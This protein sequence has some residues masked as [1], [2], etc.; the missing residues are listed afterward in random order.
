MSG[1]WWCRQAWQFG[2][3][4]GGRIAARLLLE[5]DARARAARLRVAAQD[6]AVQRLRPSR[7]RMRTLILGPGGRLRWR[8]V[9]APAP[10]G[11]FGAIVHPLA[12]AT[13]DM[14]R[15]LALGG[16]P[17]PV[18]LAF[19]HEC[20]AEVLS[21]GSEV[22]TVGPGQRVV[23]PFQISC[24]SCQACRTG[25]SANCVAVPPLSMYG[26]G[27][28]GGH[29]GG[30]FADEL[31]VPFADG[32]LVALPE[33]VAPAVAASVAD[34][35]SDAY[36]HVGPHLQRVLARGE[37]PRVIVLGGQSKRTL[38][39]A[40][41]P[42]YAG[43]I[44]KALGAGEVL[45]ID[46][47]DHVRQ[48]AARLGLNAL[49]PS[50]AKSL[51]PASLV[52]DVSATAGGLRRAIDLTAPDGICSSSGTLHPKAA[53]PTALMFG[54]NA[55]LTIGR[56]HARA[57]IPQVL[58]LMTEGRLPLQLVTTLTGSVQDA[59]VLLREHALGHSTKTILEAT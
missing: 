6:A 15:P 35:V 27:L 39:T 51:R 8:S 44:A 58:A 31:A 28:A 18:P 43:L 29:W 59:P 7:R 46:G 9:P 50:E 25:R 41:V 24:G 16:T 30:A 34:N 19:G 14:D 2:R 52:A 40:S 13:C 5:R 55:T 49:A 47:R 22:T 26:F 1:C 42:L 54:R 45:L 21:V 10:P 12:I 32:M 33:S 3:P 36:R 37:E 11:P 38:F 53:I 57:V 48:H 20:V 4:S 23:V 17:F 56:T